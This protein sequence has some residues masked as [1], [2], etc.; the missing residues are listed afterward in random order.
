[1]SWTIHYG[2]D[3]DQGPIQRNVEGVDQLD[4]MLDE[5]DHESRE[6]GFP[7]LVMIAPAGQREPLLTIGVGRDEYSILTYNSD[8]VRGSLDGGEPSSWWINDEPS[9]FPP[10]F[11]I[12]VAVARSVARDFVAEGGK[13]PSV[14]SWVG[15]ED[16]VAA[17]QAQATADNIDPETGVLAHAS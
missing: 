3:D 13:R 10:H 16:H 11:G 2:N 17:R 7:A 14:V 6:E 12:P 4:Q 9:E 5:I 8:Y 15:Y 1:M